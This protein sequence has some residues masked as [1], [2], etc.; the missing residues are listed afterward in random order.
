VAIKMIGRKL[1]KYPF[2]K[3]CRTLLA[4]LALQEVNSV[5]IKDGCVLKI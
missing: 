3:P 1:N 2:D 5:L 4:G